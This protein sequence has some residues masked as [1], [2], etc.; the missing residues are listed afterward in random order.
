MKKLALIS[1][2][3]LIVCAA[4]V[5]A[6]IVRNSNFYEG[7][8]L[9]AQ[10]QEFFESGTVRPVNPQPMDNASNGGDFPGSMLMYAS[11]GGDGP[12]SSGTPLFKKCRIKITNHFR[13]KAY[14]DA[15]RLLKEEE[16]R[17]QIMDEYAAE[18][19]SDEE[20][21]ELIDRN[22]K[23]I[24]TDEN[25]DEIEVSYFEKFKN[26]FK[27]K[28]TDATET[29]AD[30]AS[31]ESAT[32]EQSTDS[33]ENVELSGGVKEVVAQNDIVLDCDKMNY[34][35]ATEDL[36]AVGS[37]V[38]SFPPQRVT[39]KADKLV[40]N[41]ASNIIK[42]YDNV[43]IIKDNNPP[44]TGD[45]IQ[46]NM[47][48][49]TAIVTN[50][51]A[52]KMNMLVKAKDVSASEDTL[53]LENG[54]MQGEGDYILRFRSRM[55]GPRLEEMM[56]PEDEYTCAAGKEGLK[57]KVKAKDIY[58]TAKKDHDVVTVKDADI[59]IKG[60][61][62]TRIGSFT[63]HTNKN[64]EYFEANYPE[65]G[66]KPRLGMFIGPGFVFDA[67][68][69]G[70]TFKLIPFLNYKNDFGV[71][72]ALKYRSGTNYTEAYYGTAENVFILKGRQFLDDRL[73]LQYGVN[74]YLEEWWMGSGMSKYQ[75][76]A[77]YR[78]SYT[79]PN[80][81]GNRS[82][83]YRQRIS[84]GYIQDTNYNRKN[85]HLNTN[86]MG[87]TRLKYMAELAQSLYSYKNEEKLIRADLAWILQGSAALYGTGDTQ[88]IGRTGPVLHTQYKRWMQDIGYFIS[89]YDDNTPLPIFDT[90]RYGRSNV[91]ARESL[92]LNKYLTFSWVTSAN[93]SDDSPN[94]KVFQENG[95]YLAIGPDDLKLMLGYDFIREQ[96]I[97]LFTSAIDMKGT[98][99][100]YK[101]MVIKNPDKLARDDS[102]KVELVNFD[103]PK[104][105]KIKR[106]Y[107]EVINIEDPNREQL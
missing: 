101:K 74:S 102:E 64:H 66:S 85:E 8:E 22:I 28:K 89:A 77:I 53:V 97:F 67:P 4:P 65:L 76:Q 17:R 42:A 88:F 91:F 43:E 20:L 35:D 33:E 52:H 80:T 86:E 2:I 10:Q 98:S 61:Y 14:Q 45:Y 24:Y 13:T 79:I 1:L 54:S 62:I 105:Q 12:R 26:L 50:M 99:V 96:T 92:R 84:A 31:K 55:I 51:K 30:D 87:T 56:I 6:E 103:Q 41:T 16:V 39:I 107:A 25:G 27:R 21:E 63:A 104:P 59:F 46:I 68:Y 11:G 37:P 44:I 3:S 90:Y 7:N 19:I 81:L 95:F 75:V 94:G 83:Q 70:G 69:G 18:D 5:N 58:V 34:D 78:D 57:V 100:D 23:K 49:E 47:N 71:G 82:A 29:K 106:T 38:L 9:E 73:Y 15:Q 36:I 72:A 93:L 48:D 40:Y 32:S 60:N